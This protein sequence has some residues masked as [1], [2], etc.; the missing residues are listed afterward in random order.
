[1]AYRVKNLTKETRKFRILKTAE[2]FLI[3][4]GE[5]LI[6]PYPLIINR[7]DVFKVTKL[8]NNEEQILE[9]PSKKKRTKKG[10]NN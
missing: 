4:P 3:R 6:V 5:E 8:D 1:M 9:V 7:P 10:G 2:G